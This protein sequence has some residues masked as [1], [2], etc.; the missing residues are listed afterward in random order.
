[1]KNRFILSFIYILEKIYNIINTNHKISRHQILRRHKLSIEIRLSIY[2]IFD[3][4]R[5]QE[6]SRTKVKSNKRFIKDY[7][8]RY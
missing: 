2:D 5:K 6:F 3:L 7:F 8:I 4:S 1:M